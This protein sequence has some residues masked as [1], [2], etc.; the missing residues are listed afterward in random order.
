MCSSHGSISVI[1]WCISLRT[2][3]DE[4]LQQSFLD[5]RAVDGMAV[6]DDIEV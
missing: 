5:A 3:R 4:I 1:S 2:T 6:D